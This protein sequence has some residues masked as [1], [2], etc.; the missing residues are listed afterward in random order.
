MLSTSR[1]LF[2]EGLEATREQSQRDRCELDTRVQRLLGRNVHLNPN[3]LKMLRTAIIPSLREKEEAQKNA[4]RD[5][6]AEKR[7]AHRLQQPNLA[8]PPA[9]Q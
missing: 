9:E 5:K 4:G 6:A 7:Y 3:E 8:C 1:P 2:C